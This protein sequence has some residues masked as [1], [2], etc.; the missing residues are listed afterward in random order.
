MEAK[1]A[2][3]VPDQETCIKAK[4]RVV[5]PPY[6]N[7]GVDKQVAALQSGETVVYEVIGYSMNKQVLRKIRDLTIHLKPD[8]NEVRPK[9][10]LCATLPLFYRTSVPFSEPDVTMYGLQLNGCQ[11]PH[12]I[13]QDVCKDVVSTIIL[14]RHFSCVCSIAAKCILV[15][16]VQSPMEDFDEP[17]GEP[18][19]EE[20]GDNAISAVAAVTRFKKVDYAP[21]Y[22]EKERRTIT[23]ELKCV[24][25]ANL[26]NVKDLATIIMILI[27]NTLRYPLKHHEKDE[28]CFAFAVDA[29]RCKLKNSIAHAHMGRHINN[30]S[31]LVHKSSQQPYIAVRLQVTIHLSNGNTSGLLRGKRTIKPITVEEQNANYFNMMMCPGLVI[32]F[33]RITGYLCH[34]NEQY[35]LGKKLLNSAFRNSVDRK[36]LSNVKDVVSTRKDPLSKAKFLVQHDNT[37][38]YSRASIVLRFQERLN[39]SARFHALKFLL[40]LMDIEQDLNKFVEKTVQ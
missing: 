6:G 15:I 33:Q 9:N 39:S 29:L 21:A 31:V 4:R 10:K 5:N 28:M 27:K 13:S 7:S 24:E 20:L 19:Y 22:A 34:L 32:G 26:V 12:N 1:Q 11:L 25:S 14:P 37:E 18:H 35:N 36:L 23:V 2:G 16:E 30:T 40:R 17:Y 8:K 38:G 3:N